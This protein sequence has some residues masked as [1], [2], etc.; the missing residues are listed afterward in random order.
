MHTDDHILETFLAA[1]KPLAAIAADL[2]MTLIALV[3]WMDTNVDLLAAAKRAMETHIAF[4]SLKAEAAALVDL[5]NVSS[6]TT[7]E[8]RKRKSASQLLRHSAKRL[9]SAVGVPPSPPGVSPPSPRVSGEKS[10]RTEGAKGMRGVPIS[11]STTASSLDAPMPSALMPC[12]SMPSSRPNAE[13]PM[14]NAAPFSDHEIDVLMTTLARHF[15][16]D[17]TA[18]SAQPEPIARASHENAG[19]P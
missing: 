10:L 19:P 17:L 13:S 3:R 5:T 8:E 16:I 14:P 6:T 1:N 12:A 7:N 4:L 15:D 2:S 18:D 9:L 11:P